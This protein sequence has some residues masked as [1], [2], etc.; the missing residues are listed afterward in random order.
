MRK[1]LLEAILL[2]AAHGPCIADSNTQALPADYQRALL[3][4]HTFSGAG[5]ELNDA[6]QL[7]EKLA[8]S[9]PGQGYS[10][11]LKAEALSTWQLDQRGGPTSVRM[12][13][14]ALADEALRLNPKLAQAHVARARAL[15]RASDFVEA[16]R[17]VDAALK[18][19]PNLNGAMFM[20]AD[21]FRRTGMVAEAETWY[22]KFIDAT[23]DQRRKSNGYYWLAKTY[24]DGLSRDPSQRSVLLPK[25]RTAFESMLKLDPDGAYSNVNFAVFLNAEAVD[26]GAA[27]RYAQK[28]LSIMDFPMARYHV[29]IARYQKL[30]LRDLRASELREAVAQ[31]RDSTGISIED[32]IEFVS[33]CLGMRARLQNVQTRTQN[34]APFLS[35]DSQRYLNMGCRG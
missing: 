26:F 7:A 8:T 27:E 12:Q 3:L 13:V 16:Y 22:L 35:A 20:R 10:E 23:A 1:L 21:I 29:A 24:Q 6:M 5:N 18:L 30:S 19:D 28:A 17:S 14:I 9:H 32:A 11:T 4:I 33:P 2:L 31:I 34:D 25:A 15:A